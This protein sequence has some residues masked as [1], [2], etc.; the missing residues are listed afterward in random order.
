MLSSIRMKNFIQFKDDTFIHFPFRDDRAYFLVGENGSGKTSIFEAVRRCLNL[1]SNTSFSTIPKKENMYILCDYEIPNGYLLNKYER[2]IS[3]MVHF[4]N[5]ADK[6]GKVLVCVEKETGYTDVFMDVLRIQ[7]EGTE[8]QVGN[9][10]VDLQDHDRETLKKS[11]PTLFKKTYNKEEMEKY[12]ECVNRIITDTKVETL[13]IDNTTQVETKLTALSNHVVSTFMQRSIGPLQWSKSEFIQE[14]RRIENYRCARTRCE[15]ITAFLKN[16]HVYNRNKEEHFFQLLAGISNYTFKLKEKNSPDEED[17][18]TAEL[19]NKAIEILKIP[20]GIL[21]AKNLSLL[22]SSDFKT[23]LLEEPDNGMH[24][25]M[26]QIIRDIILP[27]AEEKIII[28]TSHNPAFIDSRTIYRTVKVYRDEPPI[29]TSRVILLWDELKTNDGTNQKTTRLVANEK[30]TNILFA[31]KVFFVEGESDYLFIKYFFSHLLDP[32][33]RES[34]M[35]V[36]KKANLSQ[37]DTHAL[38]KLKD[39][40]ASVHVLSMDGETNKDRW[41]EVSKRLKIKRIFL[42]DRDV[43]VNTSLAPVPC[44]VHEKIKKKLLQMMKSEQTGNVKDEGNG[45]LKSKDK[46]NG[47]GNCKGR[48]DG[49]GKSKTEGKGDWDSEETDKGEDEGDATYYKLVNNLDREAWKNIKDRKPNKNVEFNAAFKAI[50]EI[51]RKRLDKCKRSDFDQEMDEKAYLEYYFAQG[52]VLMN[53]EA[54]RKLM[55][56]KHFITE[57]TPKSVPIV[58][59]KINKLFTQHAS[60]RKWKEAFNCLQN[61]GLFVWRNGALEDAFTELIL[62]TE[63]DMSD[64]VDNILTMTER[65]KVLS[66]FNLQLDLNNFQRKKQKQKLYMA[67]NITTDNIR[68][69]ID[70]AFQ[71]CSASSDIVNL[72]KFLVSCTGEDVNLIPQ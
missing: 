4:P 53:M 23:V 71:I 22:L 45:V 27:Q 63:N 30:Y 48:V 38:E 50:Q 16:K 5:E 58:S 66:S 47:D 54:E 68:A 9:I 20:Q 33:K 29:T 12:L 7:S 25:R 43:V 61:E 19:G 46:G 39:L 10:P 67:D 51:L 26:I 8:F 56:P 70:F 14:N 31:P 59:S 34:C 3:S 44:F 64:D 57:L 60:D 28:I 40:I 17:E 21:E 62:E 2:I 35:H 52:R 6:Y 11:I 36:L 15:I 32:Q 55:E 1:Q 72:I 41:N 49:E 37:N 24:A 42:L 18:I 69:S 13:N 65:Y